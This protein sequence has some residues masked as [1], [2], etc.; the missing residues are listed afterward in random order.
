MFTLC[1]WGCK[2]EADLPNC[3]VLPYPNPFS[4]N[5][6]IQCLYP[7]NNISLKMKY[8]NTIVIDTAFINHSGA[9]GVD[10]H[11]LPDGI[12][13]LEVKSNDELYLFEMVKQGD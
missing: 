11:D 1:I 12:Y 4:D 2:K 6:F 9:Y 13:H 7:E 10:T 3:P 5:F 8:Y